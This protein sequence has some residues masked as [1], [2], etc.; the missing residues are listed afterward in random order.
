[1]LISTQDL[2]FSSFQVILLILSILVVGNFI[3]DRESNYLEGSLC[4]LVYLI[5]AVSTFFLNPQSAR[6]VEGG[7][8]GPVAAK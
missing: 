5:I 3:R 4:I 6:V 1:M 8:G 7:E 2:N